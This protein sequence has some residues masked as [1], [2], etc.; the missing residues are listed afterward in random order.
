MI[1]IEEGGII[2][3]QERRTGSHSITQRCF[4]R[5]KMQEDTRKSQ[6]QLRSMPRPQMPVAPDGGQ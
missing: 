6:D 4:T 5:K 3:R 2:C 1:K